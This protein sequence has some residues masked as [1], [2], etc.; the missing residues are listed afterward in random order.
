MGLDSIE[1]VF[2]LKPFEKMIKIKGTFPDWKMGVKGLIIVVEMK[3]KDVGPEHVEP[4]LEGNPA[5]EVTMASIKAE[6]KV[7]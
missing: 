4:F 5:K 3:F 2:I 1:T 7:F 6:A